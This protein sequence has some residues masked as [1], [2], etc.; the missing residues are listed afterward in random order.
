MTWKWAYLTLGTSFLISWNKNLKFWKVVGVPWG[1]VIRMTATPDSGFSGIQC[2]LH[3]I[4]QVSTVSRLFSRDCCNLLCTSFSLL[5]LFFFQPTEDQI[6]RSLAFRPD[7]VPFPV[8][9]C[10]GLSGL[11][12]ERI[13]KKGC[14]CGLSRCSPSSRSH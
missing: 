13:P 8:Q 2:S 1:C 11:A 6:C 5:Y 3:G 14:H 12:L 9:M 10:A 4:R 7:C